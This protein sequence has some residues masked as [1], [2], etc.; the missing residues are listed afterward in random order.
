M[1]NDMAIEAWNTVLFEKFSR[2]K[3]LFI[4][5]YAAIS[6][7]VFRRHRYPAG[8]SVL[9]I[10]CGFGDST[11]DI[12]KSLAEGGS[13]SGVDCASNF[14]DEC[15]KSAALQRV[16]NVLFFV[17]DAQRDDLGGPYDQAFSRFGTMFFELPE[18][19]MKNIRASLKPG[20]KFTQVVWRKREDN[21]WVHDA[22]LCVREILPVVS[23]EKADAHHCGPGPF[24][25]AG[26]DTVSDLLQS[27]GFERIQ[28][29]RFDSDICMGRSFDEAI[30]FALEVGPAGEII[31]LAGTQAEQLRGS[32]TEALRDVVGRYIRDDGSIWAPSSAWFVTAYNPG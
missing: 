18:S 7:E 11:I 27:A 22:E 8:A 21:P 15:K 32:V 31:R 29:E 6:K 2:F 1:S 9:D 26:P 3:Y 10:G 24:S 25:M 20:G 5:S 23:H 28:F 19:A 16:D 17:S 12:A 4:E 14:I 13:A 30:Q